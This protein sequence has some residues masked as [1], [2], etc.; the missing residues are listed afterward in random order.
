MKTCTTCSAEIIWCH[1][2]NGR[3]MPLDAK[4]EIRFV[5]NEQSEVAAARKTYASHFST[6]PNAT[7]YRTTKAEKKT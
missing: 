5:L 1:T 4:P 6:C 7:Q 2:S 3:H